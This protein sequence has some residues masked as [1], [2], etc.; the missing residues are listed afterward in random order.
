MY[1]RYLHQ[2]WYLLFSTLFIIVSRIFTIVKFYFDL[3]VWKGVNMLIVKLKVMENGQWYILS[4]FLGASLILL[5]LRTF[6]S[7]MAAPMGRLKNSVRMQL[8]TK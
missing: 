5:I 6:K 7:S 8:I 4:I 1:R 3:L 2:I